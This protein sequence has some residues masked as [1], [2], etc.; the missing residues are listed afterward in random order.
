M[1]PVTA[2]RF[3]LAF[4]GGLALNLTPCVYPLIP[5]TLSFF[6]NQSQHRLGHTALLAGCYVLGLAI[7]Y[8]LLGLAA[9]L[10]G[11]LFG[12]L[13]QR[14]L[15]L[16]SVA[17]VMVALG[18]SMCGLFELRV[19]SWIS[20]RFG[21]GRTGV[22]GALI[23]GLTVGIVAAP[24]IG[25]FVA[26]MLL[27]VSQLGSPLIG[28]WLFF[29][30]ALGLG[31]PY[32]L[33]ALFASRLHRLPKAGAWLVWIK[34]MLGCVLF[35]V[36]LYLIF[37]LLPAAAGRWAILALLVGCGVYL[38]WLSRA[39]LQGGWLWARR[40]AGLLLMLSAVGAWPAGS[41]APSPIAWVPYTEATVQ[42]AK[43]KPVLA[44]VSAD[45]CIPCREMELT[46]FRDPHVVEHASEF[47][48][49]KVDVTN[50]D[51]PDAAAF[52]ER[53]NVLG[54]PMLVVFDAQGRPRQD[55]SRAGFVSSKELLEIMAQL[56]PPN[57]SGG[58]G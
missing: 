39:S 36:A 14:P 32:L 9:S 40:A 24:C 51:D 58:A 13:L 44:D 31:A 41:P 12:A 20:S 37:P 28:F 3:V 7:T 46:T 52:I 55:L 17:L 49:V 18:L 54:V 48:M 33:L 56:I 43:G 45:W 26:G 15:V 25:P 1:E 22:A 53:Y 2:G 8:S 35:G 50:P 4:I 27:Y 21:S 11:G 42:Q 5:V 23:M 6:T 30:L 47:L 10:T 29:T 34:Q 38:G 19:P 16:V 57:H